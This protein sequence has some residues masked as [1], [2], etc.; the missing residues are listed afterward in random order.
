MLVWEEE[1]LAPRER[2]VEDA[3]GVGRRADDPALRPQKAFMTA[4]EFM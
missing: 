4:A 1:V 3:A 2:P